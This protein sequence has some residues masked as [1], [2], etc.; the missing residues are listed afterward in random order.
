MSETN[1]IHVTP[2]EIV[3]LA[4]RFKRFRGLASILHKNVNDMANKSY[5]RM[6]VWRELKTIKDGHDPLVIDEARRLIKVN[7]GEQF[8]QL[9]EA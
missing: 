3:F 2:D 7:L 9:Q 8:N 4:D 1:K 5:T 6:D